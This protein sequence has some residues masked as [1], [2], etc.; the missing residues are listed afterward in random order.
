MAT[1]QRPS[2]VP[3]DRNMGS[4]P[5]PLRQRSDFY[6]MRNAYQSSISHHSASSSSQSYSQRRSDSDRSYQTQPT[7]YSASLASRPIVHHQYTCEG[8]LQHSP[9]RFFPEK[10]PQSS[11]RA[12]VET[13]ASTAPSEHE[14]EEDMP[15]YDLPEYTAR[16]YKSGVQ[17]ASPSDFSAL[18]PSSRRL[19]IRH[20]DATEDGNMNLRLDTEVQSDGAVFDLTLFH[21]RMHDLKNREFSL[22]RYCRDSGREVCHSTWKS[23]PAEPQKR[24]GFQRSL[25]NA[26]SV[27]RPKSEV[28]VPTLASLR[29]NDSGYSSMHSVD[30]DT[31]ERPRSAGNASKNEQLMSH[32]MKMEFSNYAQVDVT[33]VG[34]GVSKRYEFEYW[35]TIYSWKRVIKLDGDT[36]QV[37]FHLTKASGEQPLAHITPVPLTRAQ[38]RQEELKGGW[39]PPCTLQLI[40]ERIIRS[41]KDVSDVVVSA[42]LLALVDNTIRERFHS[43]TTKQIL[44]PKVEYVGPKRLINEM[45]R[46][47]SGDGKHHARSQSGDSRHVRTP[48]LQVPAKAVR[49]VSY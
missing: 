19:L 7:E 23:Q 18:F 21:L 46:R 1:P 33:R 34:A 3:F 14:L 37:S 27:M 24:P 36:K 41:Q 49:Q 13:Y 31:Q 22:R 26:L 48:S 35:G 42:G 10:E 30:F 16:P 28:K 2:L 17:A 4:Q 15:E 39:I 43:K 32:T 40:D 25:S 29:R 47:D 12:S 20:D 11:P 8:R 9:E 44:L 45:F 38:A 5:H 6:D